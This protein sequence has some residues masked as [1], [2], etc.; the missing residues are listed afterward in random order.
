MLAIPAG[1]V[2]I[3]APA[4]FGKTILLGQIH[5]WVRDV[6][7]PTGWLSLEPS[8]DEFGRF[9]SYM[10]VVILRALRRD[11]TVTSV[12]PVAPA[13]SPL[14]EAMELIE[15]VAATSEP[16]AIFLDDLHEIRN[17]D[18][19]GF[20]SRLLSVLDLDQ[21]VVVGTRELPTLDVHRLRAYGK[22]VVL[23][24]RKLRFSLEETR[25]FMRLAHLDS[26]PDADIQFL[27]ER[28]E[29][30]AAAVQLAALAFASGNDRPQTL[31]DPTLSTSE[32]ADYLV[33]EVFAKQSEDTKSFL[34]QASILRTFCAELCDAV[35]E[36]VGSQEMLQ[37][38]E[39]AN[40][41]LGPVDSDRQW[42]RFHQM[43]AEFLQKQLSLCSSLSL[44]D[45]R[46]RA[47][48]WLRSNGRHAPAIEQALNA[49][50]CGLAA[51]IMNDCASGF[52]ASGRVATL[53]QWT[54]LLPSDLICSR[55]DLH[56]STALALI[57]MH[58]H[59]D[60]QKLIGLLLP[61]MA[62]LDPRRQA[63]LRALQ[64]YLAIWSDR[65]GEVDQCLLQVQSHEQYLDPFNLWTSR[66]CEA[67]LKLLRNDLVGARR[68][69]VVS[70]AELQRIGGVSSMAFA[71]A[72][73][74]MIELMQGHL[75][76]A[77]VYLEKSLAA[78]EPYGERFCT[79]N[80]MI[81]ALLAEAKY[82]TRD[83][84]GSRELLDIFMPLIREGGMPDVLLSA[85]RVRVRIAILDGEHARAV[86]MLNDLESLGALRG[87]SRVLASVC[88][89]RSRMALA[90]ADTAVSRR[91]IALANQQ[92][93]WLT[94]ESKCAY[95]NDLETPALAAIRCS[96]VDGSAKASISQLLQLLAEA[97]DTGRLMRA[98][99]LK[100][101]L[102][103]AYWGAGQ[104]PD[105]LS[106]M[107]EALA[108]AAGENVQQVFVDESWVLR[109]I[110][111]AISASVAVGAGDFLSK[112][113]LALNDVAHLPLKSDHGALSEAGVLSR[114]EIEVL[115]MVA[116]GLSNKEIARKLFRSDATIAAHLRNIYAKL[117]AS[118]RIQA[119]LIARE[120]GHLA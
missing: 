84:T 58:K 39:N 98:L 106:L 44:A 25:E 59:D 95:A 30:W 6:G 37:R 29:G 21:R 3:T 83:I 19:L 71:D 16:F 72:G 91:Y 27:H 67:Y 52:L 65:F 20:L 17:P 64:L 50:D 97:Q 48:C 109:P 26:L 66:N 112:L 31:L 10:R 60:A 79:S 42:Y 22:A 69:F 1:L 75:R 9:I 45:M 101:L 114:R 46:R 34:L 76:A 80:A 8:D 110:L 70:R 77:I 74:A 87:L 111:R 4:G 15:L 113:S 99:T 82:L 24:A 55:P 28:T 38:I 88:L 107:G 73:I 62:T 47:A 2:L 120:R 41:F 92:D 5:D 40:L 89:E 49:K 81:A 117:E 119:I 51:D 85:Y 86:E 100:I 115:A 33:H 11:R 57:S 63:H 54:E 12:S 116:S 118:G 32:I 105:S 13:D 18:I 96:I 108:T 53:V 68:L 90:T 14:A 78:W 35:M 43:F 23:D 103:Q 104:Q 7:T 102:A 36:R 56:A 93:C 61:Q 94:P